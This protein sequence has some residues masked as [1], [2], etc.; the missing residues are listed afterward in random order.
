MAST[1]LT[2]TKLPSDPRGDVALNLIPPNHS[3][4][5]KYANAQDLPSF[6]SVG[7]K[8][9]GAAA[10]AAASLGWANKKS[11]EHWKPDNSDSAYTAAAL[12]KDY[13]MAPAWEPERSTAGSKAA[14]L[15]AGSAQ[16][17]QRDHSSSQPTAWGNSAASLAFKAG[18][19]QSPAPATDTQALNR[20]GSLHAAKGAMAGLRPR[21][22]S[23]PQQPQR[24]LYPDQANAASNALSAA[25]IA[26][27]PS[28]STNIPIDE[29]GAIPYTTMNRL[30]FTSHPP[31]KPEVDEKQRADVLH[32]SAVAMAKRM[33]NQQQNMINNAKLA[34]SSSISRHG[35][36][37]ASTTSA[38][39]E[40]SPSPVGYGGSTLQEAAYRLAQ[41]R[42]AKLHEEHQANRT[43]QDYYGSAAPQQQGRIGTIRGKLTRRRSSSD[44]DL[45]EDQKRSRQI[46]QQMS[47]FNTKLSEVDEQ[48]RTRD[49][50]ALLAAAQ[51]NV[52]AQLQS[53]DERM[54]A[55]TGRVAPSLKSDWDAKAHAAAQARYDAATRHDEHEK[56]D[57]GGGK[58]MDREAVDEIAAKR[59]QPLLDEINA[60]AGRERER[61]ALQK[62]E[63]EK[64]KEEAEKE[65][66]REKEIADI[67][68]KVKEKEKEEEK[69][70]KAELKEIEKH[71]KEEEKAAKAEQK[72]L[73]KEEKHQHKL[74]EKH[75]HKEEKHKSKE[76][77][78]LPPPGEVAAESRREGENQ[79]QQHQESTTREPAATE[80]EQ[81]SSP[82]VGAKVLGATALAIS[83]PKVKRVAKQKHIKSSSMC[84]T[85]AQL[86]K[87]PTS[88]GEAGGGTSPTNKL[89]SWLKTRFRPRAKSSGAATAADAETDRGDASS[90][91]ANNA[92]ARKG[93]IGGAALAK[94]HDKN[95]STPSIDNNNN[96][97]NASMRE[98]AMA[99]RQNN[100]GPNDEV[101]GESSNNATTARATDHT[102]AAA[103]AAAEREPSIADTVSSMSSYERFMDARNELERPLTP[104]RVL[105][106]PSGSIGR[107][108]RESRF[109]ENFDVSENL[110]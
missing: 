88:D 39:E 63:E 78:V 21:A 22:R 53:M 31:V 9:N 35:A 72:R 61:K 104:P 73:S 2:Q 92:N 80:P 42:L 44:G 37:A 106:E 74:E 77:A 19:T 57:I 52:K 12:A 34:R 3:G 46:R 62:L 47:M 6:P 11:F 86:E 58:L 79:E 43:L 7:L 20:Q 4:R 110:E 15:A 56:I 81:T 14:I 41:Q 64:Q 33:Y 87:S 107:G 13:K 27:R 103:A 70:R 54:Y 109:S 98:V 93:F 45:M 49:R 24:N 71:R 30:M 16:R 60:K 8:S 5:L 18:K 40:E 90:G 108:S 10:S 105:K 95:N 1:A 29:A 28:R 36:S 32:A 25:T 94:V 100:D 83:F 38:G 26:H 99:G 65:K 101:V 75:C 97:R 50:E 82:G 85:S 91:G 69:H 84:S 89:S 51:R 23:S 96:N 76:A 67:H 59:V 55:E 17:H 66:I 102:T 68:R 48:K